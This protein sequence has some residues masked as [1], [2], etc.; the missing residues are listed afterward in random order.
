MKIA[1]N[2]IAIAKITFVFIC[3]AV[4][5][6]YIDADY[7][8]EKLF[9]VYE[10]IV[11]IFSLVLF[12]VFFLKIEKNLAY[13]GSKRFGIQG[14]IP[15]INEVSGFLLIASFYFLNKY[16]LVKRSS[17]NL[18][19]L[20]IVVLASML[21]GTKAC[22]IFI[23]ISVIVYFVRYLRSRISIKRTSVVVFVFFIVLVIVG[24]N[25]NMLLK[26]IANTRRYFIGQYKLREEKLKFTSPFETYLSLLLSGRDI[27]LKN[28]IIEI[29]KKWTS[30]NYLIGGWNYTSYSVEMDCFDL[31][32]LVGFVGLTIYV[33]I[34][35]KL[36]WGE[37]RGRCF[38]V[39]FPTSIWLVVSFFGGHLIFSAI[40]AIYLSVFLLQSKFIVEK[41]K[42]M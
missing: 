30:I 42:S 27:K 13:T 9:K 21:A 41:I 31:F 17:K 8:A 23:P 16:F 2:I 29:G 38:F 6:N 19:L 39:Y 32:A 25:R 3:W 5:K 10:T 20:I 22:L 11:I 4:I 35:I 7:K 28:F 33:V 15:A 12:L 24:I 18:F 36:L 1:R 34:Y 14:L 37:D 40:N 26:Q